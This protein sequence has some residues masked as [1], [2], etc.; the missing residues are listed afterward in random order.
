MPIYHRRDVVS[1]IA[2]KS[3]QKPTKKAVRSVPEHRLGVELGKDR[4]EIQMGLCRIVRFLTDEPA[5][6]GYRRS[7]L[8]GLGNCEAVGESR[9][10]EARKSAHAAIGFWN[11]I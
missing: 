6:H 7:L 9:V 3:N 4:R 5:N 8:R 11:L 2:T 1:I 10:I